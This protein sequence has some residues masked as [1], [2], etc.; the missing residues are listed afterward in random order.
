MSSIEKIDF[1]IVRAGTNSSRIGLRIN[2]YYSGKN[3]EVS[4]GIRG[5]CLLPIYE[6]STIV[7]YEGF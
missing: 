3:M 5:Y 4:Y 6:N 1:D 7:L 2:G